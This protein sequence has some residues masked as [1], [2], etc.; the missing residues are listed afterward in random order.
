MKKDELK[1]QLEGILTHHRGRSMAI[2]GHELVSLT[3]EENRAIRLALEDLISDG[4]PIVSATEAP[5]GY[6]L[7]TSREEAIESTAYLRSHAV[8]TFL[9]RKKIIKNTATYIKPILQGKLL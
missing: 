1:A 2:T 8:M 4:L 6:F 3:G 9:R 5:A 7:A